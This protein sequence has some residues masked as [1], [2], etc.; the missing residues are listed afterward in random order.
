MSQHFAN[1]TMLIM[2]QVM[3]T[4][5]THPEAFGQMRAHGLNQFAPAGTRFDQLGRMEDS[6]HIFLAGSHDA[7]ALGLCEVLLELER[8]KAFVGRRDPAK[9]LD[10]PFQ[11]VDVVGARRQQGEMHDHA[12]ARNA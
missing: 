12:A 1:Q 7:D 8:N 2:P 11:M 3:D 6:D 4:D 9:I 10:Q 5:P